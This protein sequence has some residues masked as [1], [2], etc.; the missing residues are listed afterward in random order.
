MSFAWPYP[1]LTP[2]NPQ[3]SRS[4]VSMLGPPG[5]DG[6]QQ[7]ATTS[8][9]G[10]WVCTFGSIL[11]RTPE[12]VRAIRAWA[13]YLDGGQ[14]CVVP[15][16]DTLR[17]PR[18]YAGGRPQ[19]PSSPPRP[20]PGDPFGYSPGFGYPMIVANLVGAAAL[21]AT[22]IV[23]NMVRG[24]ALMGGHEFSLLHPTK[25]WRKY[26]VVRVSAVDGQ[27]FTCA[28]WPPLREAVADGL[29][30]EFDAPRC[31][32]R[33]QPD[34]ADQLEPALNLNRFGTVDATFIEAF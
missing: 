18:P 15:S 7:A 1:L 8:G 10:H 14:T 4:Q 31:L 23:I 22:S 28:I 6:Q 21:R 24:S 5:L 26:R 30:A 25:G 29:A 27:H 3:W 19:R 2:Q 11:I 34:K 13:A 32:M 17:A 20:A 16:F 9:G 12:Q 33:I